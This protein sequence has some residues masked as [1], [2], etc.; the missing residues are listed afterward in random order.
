MGLVLEAFIMVAIALQVIEISGWSL[1]F[2]SSHLGLIY[3][4]QEEK[5]KVFK[6]IVDDFKENKRNLYSLTVVA[7]LFS[8]L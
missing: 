8:I 4:C 2:H 1:S 5:R 3:G 7:V 6:N